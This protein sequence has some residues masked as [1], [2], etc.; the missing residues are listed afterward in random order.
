MVLIWAVVH[1]VGAVS[2]FGLAKTVAAFLL[3]M[4]GDDTELVNDN[5]FDE[6]AKAACW[7]AWQ[8]MRDAR[9]EALPD[10]GVLIAA[11]LDG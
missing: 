1:C 8:K 3:A 9:Y 10:V 2:A 6:E 11:S 5:E 7:R 4:A